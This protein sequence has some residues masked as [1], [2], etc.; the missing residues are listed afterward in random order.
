M[1]KFSTL[2]KLP[3]DPIYGMQV[4][5]K[6]DPRPNKINLSIGVCQEPDGKTVKFEAVTQAEEELSSQDLS[7]EYLPIIGYAPFITKAIE[8]VCGAPSK[9]LFGMQTV[10][11][12]GA[13]YIASKL[14]LRSGVKEIFIPTPSWPNHHLLFEAA[15]LIVTNYPYYDQ[16][17]AK[18]DFPA[19]IKAIE[20][21][22]EESA[23][24]LQASCHNPTG[25]DP[26][27]AEWKVLSD[28]IL[29]R[30]LIPLFDLAYQGL[31]TNLE[32]DAEPIRLFLEAG[33]EMMVAT[34]FAKNFG[35]YND[36]AGALIVHSSK[37]AIECLESHAKRIARTCYSSPP[38]HGAH[39]AAF[40]L[41]DH[42]LT[43]MWK[44]ELQRVCAQ[45]RTQREI[46]F[47]ALRQ[48]NPPF[49]FDHLMHTNGLFCLFDLSEKDVLQLREK[50][51]LYVALDGRI[52]LSAITEEKA[53]RIANAFYELNR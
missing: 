5:F 35:L 49:A 15:G 16:S 34:T 21:M 48:K 40:L 44:N 14:L 8:L 42:K 43:A 22:P 52:C 19:L 13:L 3:A 37:E 12:T 4:V 38:A 32:R 28:L 2:T 10:G 50:E 33:H 29:K 6:S 31:G 17:Q 51:A 7:K 46:L 18:L 36:R 23:I 30:K 20:K 27:I 9:P 47:E 1:T 25:I 41:Q 24:L 11:G 45:L 26:T 39:I 53:T